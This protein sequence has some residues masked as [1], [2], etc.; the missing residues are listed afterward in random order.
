M[1]KWL[2]GRKE[3]KKQKWGVVLREGLPPKTAQAWV[4]YAETKKKIRDGTY[5]KEHPDAKGRDTEFDEEIIAF[6]HMTMFWS[7]QPFDIQ[8]TDPY[9]HFMVK[10]QREGLIREY[11][12][13]YYH[14]SDWTPPAVLDMS[15][16]EAL[17]DSEGM[18]DHQPPVN[19]FIQLG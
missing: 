6:N 19:S 14:Q 16:L 2:L 17:L 5:A 10:V 9:L 12:W 8:P 3:E 13:K 1:L 18:K 4:I 15:R 7:Q 11:V